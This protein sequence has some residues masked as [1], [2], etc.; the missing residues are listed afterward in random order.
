MWIGLVKDSETGE[1]P[2]PEYTHICFD[3][4]MEDFEPL[5]RKIRQTGVEIWQENKTEGASL[6]FLDPT[7]HKLEIHASDLPTRLEHA[8]KHPWNGLE[9]FV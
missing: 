7:G 2:L 9:L 6:Y 1:K 4:S 8:R 3:V 5:S